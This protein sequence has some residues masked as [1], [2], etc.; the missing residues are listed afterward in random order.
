MRPCHDCG[1]ERGND[2]HFCR[3]CGAILRAVDDC[4][5]LNTG[6][7]PNCG[8]FGVLRVHGTPRPFRR[9]KCKHC[10]ATYKTVELMMMHP[11]RIV[12]SLAAE[13]CKR[14]L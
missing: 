6:E 7:C 4:E 13:T 12:F 1:V 10:G 3:A 2:D 8:R 11:D 5:I 9:L 14:F